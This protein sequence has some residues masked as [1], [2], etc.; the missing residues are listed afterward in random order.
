MGKQSK[1]VKKLHRRERDVLRSQRKPDPDSRDLRE[2][3]MQDSIRVLS[4]L[5][6]WKRRLADWFGYDVLGHEPR[7]MA[8]ILMDVA[9]FD[10]GGGD[11]GLKCTPASM[12]FGV[13]P[14]DVVLFRSGDLEGLELVVASVAAA[15]FRVEDVATFVS[16][17]DVA[18]RLLIGLEKKSYV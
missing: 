1:L 15:D 7:I 10:Y 11:Y 17:T 5:R 2:E 14:G 4:V 16:D 8:N 3:R 13:Q 9:R 6:G 12:E 18:S